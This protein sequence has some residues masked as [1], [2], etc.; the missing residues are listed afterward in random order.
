MPTYTVLI[1]RQVGGD[2]TD[3][4]KVE[5]LSSLTMT[6]GDGKITITSAEDEPI[7]VGDHTDN[8][9]QITPDP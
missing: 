7:I 9:V 4:S 1:R 2:N 8:N 3:V 6:A 5:L